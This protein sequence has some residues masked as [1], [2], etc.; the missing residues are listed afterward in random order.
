VLLGEGNG[1]FRP[2]M[3]W[4]S[5]IRKSIVQLGID[6]YRPPWVKDW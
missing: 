6:K 2:R 3:E 5:E 1:I 4:H